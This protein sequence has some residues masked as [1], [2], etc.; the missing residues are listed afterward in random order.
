MV[1]EAV[2]R[3]LQ[4]F[5]RLIRTAGDQGIAVVLDRRIL[6]KRYGRRFI[7]SLP[8]PRLY[9]GS[10]RD[11]PMVAQRWLAGERLPSSAA[12]LLANEPWDV[13]PPENF[14][15]ESNEEP[16]WFWGA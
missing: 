3:F 7:D 14:D 11:L 5:G 12:A 1:P 15:E 16:S 10:R 2:L 9:Q 6:T 13:P 4:G 8:E